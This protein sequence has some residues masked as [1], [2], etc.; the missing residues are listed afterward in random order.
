MYWGFVGIGVVVLSWFGVHYISRHHPRGLQQALKSVTHPMQLLTLNRLVPQQDY[1]EESI[2]AYF[3]PNGK[4]PVREDW[5][6]LAENGFRDFKLHVG[7]VVENPVE[8]PVL[9][10]RGGRI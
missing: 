3:W 10:S 5:K 1:S 7:G 4:M 9:T 8:C 6:S 2:S